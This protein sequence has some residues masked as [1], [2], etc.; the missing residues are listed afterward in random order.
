MRQ[1]HVQSNHFFLCG[2]GRCRQERNPTNTTLWF[3]TLK[4]RPFW[5]TGRAQFQAHL[6]NAKIRKHVYLETPCRKIFDTRVFSGKKGHKGYKKM[7]FQES[8]YKAKMQ[9][10]WY[11]KKIMLCG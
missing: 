9:N 3:G 11:I 1:Y 2:A 10:I 5:R 6:S 8:R 4:A 7:T